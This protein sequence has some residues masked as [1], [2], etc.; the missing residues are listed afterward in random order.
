[1]TQI[2]TQKKL[3]ELAMKFYDQELNAFRL[4]HASNKQAL[5]KSILLK[6]DESER[7]AE[8]QVGMV[9]GFLIDKYIDEYIPTNNY[10]DIEESVLKLIRSED[11]EDVIKL[12]EHNYYLLAE[13]CQLAQIK[14]FLR[15]IETL[16]GDGDPCERKSVT[17]W[18]SIKSRNKQVLV[19]HQLELLRKKYP[20]EAQINIAK[21]IAEKSLG[22]PGAQTLVRDYFDDWDYYKPF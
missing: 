1:M 22:P 3:S 4:L 8:E 16:S 20:N 10:Q 19:N 18:G 9:I 7:T 17:K 21:T 14:V 11:L 6:G 5:Y 2:L 12:N 13:K 15:M